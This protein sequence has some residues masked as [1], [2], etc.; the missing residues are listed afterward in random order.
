M[1]TKVFNLDIITRSMD[2]CE[3][4]VMCSK[5]RVQIPLGS[6]PKPKLKLQNRKIAKI[7][8]N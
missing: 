5:E 1:R 8:W 2:L 7:R 3:D 6:M 4:E